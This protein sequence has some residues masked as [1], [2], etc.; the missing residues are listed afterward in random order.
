MKD[1]VGNLRLS[2]IQMREKL[3]SLIG[4]VNESANHTATSSLQLK[5]SD[6]LARLANALNISMSRF[7]ILKM[8]PS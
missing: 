7:Q 6:D 8:P 3:G 4:Q 2:M 5:E 1:E